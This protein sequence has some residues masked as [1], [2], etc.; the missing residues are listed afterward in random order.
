MIQFT[1]VLYTKVSRIHRLTIIDGGSCTNVAIQRLIEK[2]ALKTSPYP[3]PYK[4]QWLSE[5]GELVVD[6]QVLIYFSI[7]KYI[8]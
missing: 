1:Q 7:E 8:V 3:R 5:N 4:L 6:R 2:F